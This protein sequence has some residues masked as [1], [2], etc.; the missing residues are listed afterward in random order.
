MSWLSRLLGRD[1]PQQA[2]FVTA[3][4]P[5]EELIRQAKMVKD[6][7]VTLVS[8][9]SEGDVSAKCR[10]C[11]TQMGSVKKDQLLWFLC[12]L[13]GGATFSPLQI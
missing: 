1:K 13:C 3:A 7:C 6:A 2:G 4:V 10:K 8:R 12:P 5:E 11:S 9:G